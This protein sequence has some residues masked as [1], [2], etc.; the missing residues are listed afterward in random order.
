M[1]EIGMKIKALNN[2]TRKFN[3]NL[4]NAFHFSNKK[5]RPFV[6]PATKSTHLATKSNIMYNSMIHFVGGMNQSE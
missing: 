5:H 2:V 1:P 3:K 4:L 6:H